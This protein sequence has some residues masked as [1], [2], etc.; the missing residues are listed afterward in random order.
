M[1]LMPHLTR[2]RPPTRRP[3]VVRALPRIEQLESRV[4]PYSIS[5][6]AWPNPQLITLSFV[7]DGTNLGG[8]TSN[9]VSTFNTK[10]GSAATWQNQILKAAQLWAQQTN[11]NF[12]VISDSGADEGLGNYQQGDP[13]I[14][15][16]RIS[17][18]NYGTGNTTLAMAYMPPPVNNYSI[19]G[20]FAFNTGQTWNIGSTYDLM[21]VA[22]HEI[23]HALGLLHSDPTPAVM[24][25]YYLTRYTALAS[26]DIA[27]IRNIYSSNNARSYDSYNN[28]IGSFAAAADLTGLIDSNS[29]VLKTGLDITTTTE[30]EYFTITAPATTTGTMTVTVQSSGLSLLAPNV[31][32]YNSSQTQIGYKSGVG[33]YGTSVTV[34]ITGVSAGQQFYV[35]VGGADTTAFG[36][37]AYALTFAF[38]GI[39]PPAVPL[40][41]TQ[42]LNGNPIHGGGGEA[43][44]AGDPR[45]RDTAW[46]TFGQTDDAPP[47]KASTSAV[48]ATSNT[49]S[50]AMIHGT[51]SAFVLAATANQI[52]T[53][54]I[55]VAGSKTVVLMPAPTTPASTF[56]P[57]QV[58]LGRVESG[59]G[60]NSADGVLEENQT[61]SSAPGADQIIAPP[62][63]NGEQSDTTRDQ[64]CLTNDSW[65]QTCEAY[66]GEIPMLN[67]SSTNEDGPMVGAD[68]VTA[69]V[70]PAVAIAMLTL[71]GG[72]WCTYPEQNDRPSRRSFR[73]LP[74]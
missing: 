22:A 71:F 68:G 3:L 64:I 20:D 50:A 39:A 52:T 28:S 25:S 69:L 58:N 8:G 17:G 6:D 4:V 10:F 65:P 54:E 46:D 1:R 40:P 59:G 5:G 70:E 2:A 45:G 56:V 60:N 44:Q 42:V 38:A 37:G 26:D 15:D 49:Q 29:T 35:K 24:Y 14:G 61:E 11:I 21:T 16:I 62:S 32:V 31:T 19:A 66:F 7:P 48:T 30:K 33:H 73:G 23:G 53:Q 57:P 36:T 72:W 47:P 18:F 9:L 12:S 55:A 41:N 67:V 34:N 63:A 27:G 13:T 74:N 51:E 43:E